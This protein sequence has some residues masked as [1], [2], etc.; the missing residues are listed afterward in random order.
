MLTQWLST[1]NITDINKNESQRVH[2]AARE[3]WLGLVL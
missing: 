1:M 2:T 3:D